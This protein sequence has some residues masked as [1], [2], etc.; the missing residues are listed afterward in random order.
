MFWH[1]NLFTR[2]G[3]IVTVDVHEKREGFSARHASHRI[4]H[5][6][7]DSTPGKSSEK[8]FKFDDQYFLASSMDGTVKLYDHRIIQRGA[9][10]TY[11]GNVNSHT[12]LQLG[13][14]PSERFFISGGEDCNL[15]LWSIKSGELLFEDKLTN[16]VTPTVCWQKAEAFKGLQDERQKL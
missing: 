9:V 8:W 5:S 13:V 12:R 6:P 7:L 10:Q 16:T 15:R 14:D 11:E 3:A 4:R 2:N 1:N